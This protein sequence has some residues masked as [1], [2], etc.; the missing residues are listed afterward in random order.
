MRPA[1]I[2][3][4]DDLWIAAVPLAARGW[5]KVYTTAVRINPRGCMPSKARNLTLTNSQAACLIALRHCKDSKTKIAIEAKLDLIKTST[6]L[7]ALARLG[8]AKQNQAKTWWPTARGKT[9]RYETAPDRPR[10]SSALPGAGGRRLLALLDR[11]MRGFAT[12][13]G[14]SLPAATP[15]A[16]TATISSLRNATK[17]NVGM[18]RRTRP[19]KSRPQCA[20]RPALAIRCPTEYSSLSSASWLAAIPAA[21]RAPMSQM[22]PVPTQ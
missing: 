15:N 10:R 13:T 19:T 4:A 18:T 11:P 1:E 12:G 2:F 3:R 14:R 17:S 9:C 16:K 5:A 22:L 8:L 7:R 21:I 20:R 6:T